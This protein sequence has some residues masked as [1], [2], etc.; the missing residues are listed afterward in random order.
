MSGCS[1]VSVSDVGP[2]AAQHWF[3]VS[4][5]QGRR[6][7]KRSLIRGRAPSKDGTLSMCWFNVGPSSATLAQQ[8][9]NTRAMFARGC[10]WRQSQCYYTAR[11]GVK[12]LIVCIHL[13]LTLPLP[14]QRAIVVICS[15]HV[16][17]NSQ[18]QML[19]E[20][21]HNPDVGPALKQHWIKVTC[22]LVWR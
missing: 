16:T 8:W 13:R 21:G 1:W 3:N 18:Y 9:K 5:L 4:C 12:D 14:Q 22:L 7:L 6:C 11:W 10:S 20:M 19:S 15:A 17:A 2:T